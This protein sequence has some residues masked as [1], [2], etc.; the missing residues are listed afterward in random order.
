MMG[1]ERDILNTHTLRKVLNN[2]EEN[3]TMVK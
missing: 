2:I 3:L 1:L